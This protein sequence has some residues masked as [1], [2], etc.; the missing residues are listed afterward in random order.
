[1]YTST[2]NFEC[3]NFHVIFSSEWMCEAGVIHG[4]K[5]ST[6][7]AMDADLRNI[8]FFFSTK[9]DR[10]TGSPNHGHA[11]Y[12]VKK[13]RKKTRDAQRSSSFCYSLTSAGRKTLCI[14]PMD[15][16]DDEYTSHHPTHAHRWDARLLKYCS[17]V[18]RWGAGQLYYTCQSLSPSQIWNTQDWEVLSFRLVSFPSFSPSDP[19]VHH[20]GLFLLHCL[21]IC[22]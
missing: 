3:I 21:H 6:V 10:T 22:V 17:R 12:R 8:I 14:I 15:G 7:V 19:R 18:W 13:G 16:W 20:S 2:Y 5:I 1:M 4:M 9:E 11:I